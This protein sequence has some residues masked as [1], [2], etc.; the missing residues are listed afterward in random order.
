MTLA[1][2]YL[3]R[4]WSFRL[5]MALGRVSAFPEQQ[6]AHLWE[7]RLL[8]PPAAQYGEVGLQALQEI[9]QR[10][11]GWPLDLIADW[12][13]HV[14]H[15][16]LQEEPKH[17]QAETPIAALDLWKGNSTGEQGHGTSIHKV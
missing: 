1:T 2:I 5:T 16:L 11:H 10:R 13:K 12:Q 14:D 4:Q 8:P 17:R 3:Q 6:F 15:L 7:G 9:E